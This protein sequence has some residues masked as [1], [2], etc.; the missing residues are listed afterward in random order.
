MRRAHIVAD[1]VHLVFFFSYYPRLILSHRRVTGAKVIQKVTK[2][3]I[4]MTLF[5]FKIALN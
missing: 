2:T 3:I 5:Y 4:I 1:I